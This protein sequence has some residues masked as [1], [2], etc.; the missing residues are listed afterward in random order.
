MR[1]EI[2]LLVEGSS[3]GQFT[4]RSLGQSIFVQAGTM[5]EL[6][7]KVLQAVRE[8][9]DEEHRPRAVRL[10]VVIEEVLPL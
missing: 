2:V 5:D 8:H 10:H 7:V 6:R 9:F 4:A 3:E 1:N